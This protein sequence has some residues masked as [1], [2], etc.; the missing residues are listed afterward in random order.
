MLSLRLVNATDTHYRSVRRTLVHSPCS[1][2]IWIDT[3]YDREGA[4]GITSGHR[5]PAFEH[6]QC[7]PAAVYT[8]ADFAWPLASCVL[9]LLPPRCTPISRRFTR[10]HKYEIVMWLCTAHTAWT[11]HLAWSTGRTTKLDPSCTTPSS[12]TT[13]MTQCWEFSLPI[14]VPCKLVLNGYWLHR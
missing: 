14:I 4:I 13:W 9:F 2:Y 10:M 8:F 6:V 5:E 7:S 12:K 1:A 11:V 3:L